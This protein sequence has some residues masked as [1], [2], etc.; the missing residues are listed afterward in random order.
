MT[1]MLCKPSRALYTSFYRNI[2]KTISK[3]LT[4][5]VGGN[6]T[7]E[8]K[9]KPEIGGVCCMSGC[10]NCVWIKYAEELLDY[11][12]DAGGG[13]DKV[14]NAIEEEVHDDNLKAYLRFEIG[15]LMKKQK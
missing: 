6:T 14:M 5:E 9:K 13:S 12:K 2:L 1:S 3:T 11:Y 8:A 7:V 15:L 4:D 10:A